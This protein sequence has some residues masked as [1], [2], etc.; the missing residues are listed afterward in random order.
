MPV[1]LLIVIVGVTV[2][3]VGRYIIFVSLRLVDLLCWIV[4]RRLYWGLLCSL[5]LSRKKSKSSRIYYWS[6]SHGSVVL[7]EGLRIRVI[8]F[9]YPGFTA[10]F[11]SLLLKLDPGLICCF[12]GLFTGRHVL[13]WRLP[14]LRTALC[15]CWRFTPVDAPMSNFLGG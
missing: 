11:H 12:T 4:G 9:I 5:F 2:F 14:A 10:A 1:L 15:H 6:I 8:D 7:W 3:T 13:H